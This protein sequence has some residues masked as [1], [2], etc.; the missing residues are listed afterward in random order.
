MLTLDSS[1]TNLNKIGSAMAGKLK[2]IDIFSLRDLIYYFPFR[3][4]NFSETTQIKNLKANTKANIIGQ[5][6]LI[7]NKKS[8][9]KRMNITEALI[10]DESGSIKAIWFNQPF[11]GRTLKPGDYVSLSGKIDNDF[12]GLVIKSP[13][14][15]KN[16]IKYPE[17]KKSVHTQ[18]LVPSYNLTQNLTQ[19]QLRFLISQVVK[20]IPLVNEWLPK[21]IIKKYN[22]YELKEALQ[23]IHFP[24]N[25]KEVEN[26]KKRLGFDELFLT[27]LKSQ[28]AK[29][30]LNKAKAESFQFKEKETKK[31]VDALPFQLTNAQK[32]SSWEI[33][34]D[35]EKEK[36]MSRLLEGDVGSGKTIVAA[37]AMLNVSLHKRGQSALM[38]PTEILAEQHYN[39]LKMLFKNTK[40]KIGLFTRSIKK[41]NS[42]DEPIK[43]NIIK[44]EISSGEIKIIIGTHALIQEKIK[45]KDLG[46]AIIDE[47]HRFGVEQRKALTQKSGNNKTVPHLL[48]MTATPIP[49]TLAMTIYGDLDISYINEMPKG[50]K[51]I[52]TKV[53]AE[54]K[55]KPAYNFIK[56]EI[57]KGR[58]AF[59]ICPL[60]DISDKLGVASVKEEYEK[61]SKQIFPN[62]RLSMLHGKLKTEEKQEIMKKFKSGTIDILVATSVIEVGVDIP[63][64]TMIIIEGA[65]RFGL[66]QL[67]QFRGRVGR[68]DEQS[69]CFLFTESKSEKTLERL[70]ALAKY[71]DGFNLSKIDLK[72]RGPGEVYGI[73]QKGFP[74]L[75]VASIFDYELIKTAREAVLE[76]LRDD[77]DLKEHSLIKEKLENKYKIEYLRS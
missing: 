25:L 70:N 74:E 20:L 73:A 57:K 32:K 63:N 2:R 8:R 22:L 76:V 11:I 43:P 7:Q 66:A 3:Y 24:K 51:T 39:N 40:I 36:P 29:T 21:K 47:Q 56:K 61:L 42:S 69:Y 13:E 62:L 16:I 55:R 33:L 77:P 4:E 75:K 31:F 30:E 45:F 1:I 5:I 19:K 46:L 37:L 50:R 67:H 52:I 26:A 35:I 17:G 23:K 34:R 41:I 60:I 12:T 18:G 6:E 72:F 53:V 54:E 68:A 65:D 44:K 71:T 48:S 10:S 14:Y 9:V 15:E 58:Q 27:L 38:V 59:V 64:A 28:I 49:R